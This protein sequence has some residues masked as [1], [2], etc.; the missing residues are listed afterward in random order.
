[1]SKSKA[2]T[3]AAL[4]VEDEKA[5]PQPRAG[6]QRPCLGREGLKICLKEGQGPS[7]SFKALR[8]RILF[9]SLSWNIIPSL[10][11][12]TPEPSFPPT[13]DQIARGDGERQRV[14]WEECFSQH[15]PLSRLPK[16]FSQ[17]FLGENTASPG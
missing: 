4:A 9:L 6:A 17:S 10:E 2:R 12:K 7:G 3:E 14:V 1:M 5:D 11:P 13:P 16:S 15:D 8:L